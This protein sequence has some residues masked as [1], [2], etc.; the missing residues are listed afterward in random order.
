[1][2]ENQ[3]GWLNA[4]GN[5]VIGLGFVF[6]FAF[7]AMFAWNFGVTWLIPSMNEME[8]LNSVGLTVAGLIIHLLAVFWVNKMLVNK[9]MKAIL[10]TAK[11][12]AKKN[13]K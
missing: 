7:V 3:G 9:R 4:F 11:S 5:F 10:D 12:T 2:N 6:T 8:Y 13:A 1:M